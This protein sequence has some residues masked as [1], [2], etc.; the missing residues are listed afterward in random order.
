M[1]QL[2]PVFRKQGIEVTVRSKPKG[3]SPSMALRIARHVKAR[4]IEVIHSHDLGALIYGVCAKWATGNS[5]RL[6]HTQHSFVHLR[7]SPLYKYYERFFTLFVDGLTV[8][9]ADSKRDYLEL[10]V[11]PERISVI[12]NGVRFPE[13]SL[14]ARSEKVALREH[15]LAQPAAC[16]PVGVLRRFRHDVWLLYLSRVHGRKGQDHAVR[17]WNELSAEWRSRSVLL[18]VGPETE[19]GQVA[20]L[21]GMIKTAPDRERI[22]YL[23]A[24]TEPHVWLEMADVFLSCSEFEGMP[25]GPIEAAGAGLPMVLSSIPG[26]EVLAP[27][28]R[29]YPLK[30]PAVGASELRDALSELTNA[31]R[32]YY[33][34]LWNKNDQ[35]RQRFSLQAMAERYEELYS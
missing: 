18:F 17:L 24:T 5:V 30:D 26:H 31:S 15:F 19:A 9:S 29:Q 8:V 25:L 16:S 14:G 13:R 22:H 6:I 28:S 23:G 27:F 20:K 3:F 32:E 11:K 33:E 2:V 10:G 12:A 21:R 7:R 4:G 35:A 1:T 34:A